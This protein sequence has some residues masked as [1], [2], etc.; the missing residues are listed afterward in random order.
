MLLTGRDVLGVQ[1]HSYPASREAWNA[2]G[3]CSSPPVHK[4]QVQAGLLTLGRSSA[5][6]P[7]AGQRQG[8]CTGG[9]KGA[10]GGLKPVCTGRLGRTPLQG[11]GGSKTQG[12][13]LSPPAAPPAAVAPPS[14][15]LLQDFAPAVRLLPQPSPE[16]GRG[17][18][19]VASTAELY[20]TVLLLKHRAQQVR[21]GDAWAE[22]G[23]HG[24]GCLL[25]SLLSWGGLQSCGSW[26]SGSSSKDGWILT[27][28]LRFLS[29]V[30]GS[31]CLCLTLP[32]AGRS[33]P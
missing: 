3:G 9:S 29:D 18:L 26:R 5:E 16:G 15:A 25:R 19:D 17:A 4:P 2:P 12:A 14:Q 6:L 21:A 27:A 24:V 33:Q 8:G 23:S 31:M 7:A 13:V 10:A 28:C 32:L 20:T 22:P 1:L 11:R 30:L